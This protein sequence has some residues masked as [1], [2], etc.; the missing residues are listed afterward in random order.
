MHESWKCD[1]NNQSFRQPIWLEESCQSSTKISPLKFNAYPWTCNAF[2][3]FTYPGA[4]S[5]FCS[6]GHSDASNP[7]ILSSMCSSKELQIFLLILSHNF[8]RYSFA[9]IVTETFYHH[10]Y[11]RITGVISLWWGVIHYLCVPLFHETWLFLRNIKQDDVLWESQD[12][13]LPCDFA[14]HVAIQ[15]TQYWSTESKPLR[16]GMDANPPLNGACGLTTTSN[17]YVNC[18]YNYSVLWHWWEKLCDRSL[19]KISINPMYRLLLNNG[20]IPTT[21]AEIILHSKSWCLGNPKND[22]NTVTWLQIHMG[23]CYKP[24]MWVGDNQVCTVSSI[25]LT[26]LKFFYILSLQSVLADAA[27]IQ[28]AFLL[29]WCCCDSEPD[30][31]TEEMWSSSVL[32]TGHMVSTL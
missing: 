3:W 5:A 16:I 27:W 32:F 18:F 23:S 20:F 11:Q 8:A 30:R 24:P 2:W 19:S 29:A 4:W 6:A 25:F 26:I 21:S 7:G 9:A 28:T 14:L 1:V 12:R 13:V 17:A 22:I 31:Q 15:S 10:E